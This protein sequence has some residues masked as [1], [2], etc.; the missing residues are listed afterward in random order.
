MLWRMGRD[1]VLVFGN[2]KLGI[3]HGKA[4]QKEERE[5]SQMMAAVG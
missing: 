3:V 2:K 5:R 4:R 1:R